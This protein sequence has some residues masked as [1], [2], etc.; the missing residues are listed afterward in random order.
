MRP[1]NPPDESHPRLEGLELRTDYLL[2]EEEAR[3]VA[4]IDALPWNTD[5]ARRRQLYGARYDQTPSAPFPPFLARLA[6]RVEEEGLL[7]SPVVNSVVNE[8]LPGEGIALHVDRPQFG[9]TVVSISLLS[10]AKME[11]RPPRA[12][13]GP[14]FEIDLPRRSLL[15]LDSD[16]RWRW[17]HGIAHRQ[18]D[19]VGGLLR[20]RGRRISIT[21]RVKALHS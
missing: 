20:P 9:D 4:A 19:L 15:R 11:F 1:T 5:W 17:R 18:S 10:A 7:P 14:A 8:Y 6:Q 13:D 2:A 12:I 21:L 3:L 16:A